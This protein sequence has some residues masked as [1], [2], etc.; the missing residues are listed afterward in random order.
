[1][2]IVKF[3]E[4]YRL[5]IYYTIALSVMRGIVIP[6]FRYGYTS[7]VLVQLIYPM[8]LLL[9]L[10]ISKVAHP[11]YWG[12]LFVGA[13]GIAMSFAVAV[14]KYNFAFGRDAFDSVSRAVTIVSFSAATVLFA[15]ILAITRVKKLP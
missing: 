6:D 7:V 8:L 11:G 14:S 12:Y 5:F 3:I 15:V 1:M 9:P 13:L 10:L 2:T 4:S